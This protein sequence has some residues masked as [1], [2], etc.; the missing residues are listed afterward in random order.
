VYEV[1]IFSMEHISTS[2]SLQFKFSE[3]IYEPEE[4]SLFY[5]FHVM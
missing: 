3:F 2:I 5:L 1:N 4:A